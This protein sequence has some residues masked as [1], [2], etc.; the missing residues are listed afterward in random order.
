MRGFGTSKI[1]YLV[2]TFIVS[3]SFVRPAGRHSPTLGRVVAVIKQG[4]HPKGCEVIIRYD[5]SN[6]PTTKFWWFSFLTK[7][8]KK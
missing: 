1:P 4:L 2:G 7:G 3:L 6:F 8:C 5:F